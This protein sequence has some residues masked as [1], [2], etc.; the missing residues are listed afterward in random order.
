[1]E[2]KLCEKAGQQH[3]YDKQNDYLSRFPL[4]FRECFNCGST[5]HFSTR[6]YQLAQSGNF[7]KR[8]FSQNYG[9]ISLTQRNP[10]IIV[11][12]EILITVVIEIIQLMVTPVILCNSQDSTIF[13]IIIITRT[14][15]NEMIRTWMPLVMT[16]STTN[17]ST[18]III[19]DKQTKIYLDIITTR[20]QE[21]VTSTTLR[22]G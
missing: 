16:N 14:I 4:E 6:D 13:Q 15:T 3:P 22:R 2:T 17:E 20:V 19:Q 21:N 9:R 5:D 11:S 12:P 18:I 1:M 10:N 8:N 7:N